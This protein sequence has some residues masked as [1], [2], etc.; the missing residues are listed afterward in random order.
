MKLS[1]LSVVLLAYNEEDLIASTIQEA[2]RS[3]V[4]A[5]DTYEIVVVGYAGS[6]DGTNAVVTNL[7]QSDSRIRLVLQGRNERG[8]GRALYL[9][10]QNARYEWILQS[11]ADGQ[12]D[13]T[14]L[15]TLLPHTTDPRVA[16]VHGYRAPRR[17]PKERIVM[18]TAYN[19]ALKL[20]YRIPL[21]DVD[22]AFK[23][24]RGEVV[25]ALTIRSCSG[26]GIAEL[27]MRLVQA[28]HRIV[29][30]PIHHRPRA[31]GAALA[32]KGTANPFGL[33][34]PNFKLIR[35]TLGEMVKMRGELRRG[36]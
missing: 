6:T 17:D 3:A 23:L 30:L 22:S 25:R 33:E 32:D 2:A 11:D 31:G 12:Y 21:R 9:G 24:M 1:S 5:A 29:Q 35:G 16:L 4:E 15:A 28:G 18:A 10:I 27:V 36:T 19:M 14:D 13:F 26:F 34:L 7:S 8:Y 20:L